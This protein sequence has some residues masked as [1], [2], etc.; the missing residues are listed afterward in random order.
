MAEKAE[1]AVWDDAHV[2][3]FISICKEEIANGNRPLGFLNPIGWKNLVEKFEARTGKNLTRT[4]LK[5]KWDSMKKEYTWFMELKIAA[6]GLGWDDAKQTVD[7]SKEWWDE[8]LQVLLNPIVIARQQFERQT[9]KH[10]H[11]PFLCLCL[12]CHGSKIAE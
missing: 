2:V 8:H 1:K 12:V 3:H 6:T 4:Q 5:N 7:A 10:S 9:W 11:F